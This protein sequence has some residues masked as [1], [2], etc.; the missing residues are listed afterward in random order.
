MNEVV[1]VKQ[2]VRCTI[3]YSCARRKFYW[4]KRI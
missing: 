3:S 1:Q 2:V 4:E